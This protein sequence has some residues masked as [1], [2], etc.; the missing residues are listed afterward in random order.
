M[1]RFLCELVK[2]Y[3]SFLAISHQHKQTL[4]EGYDQEVLGFLAELKQ[5]KISENISKKVRFAEE[6][7]A[8]H[9]DLL[10][11][12]RERVSKVKGKLK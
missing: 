12:V 10:K 3:Q 2:S 8:R 4:L 11:Q 7:L 5:S 6:S 1:G 9:V